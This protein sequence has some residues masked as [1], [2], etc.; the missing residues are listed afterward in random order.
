MNRTDPV[1]LTVS[2]PAKRRNFAGHVRRRIV[3]RKVLWQ[4]FIYALLLGGGI[5]LMIPLF[6]MVSTSLKPEDQL[7]IFLAI[8]IPQPLQWSNYERA[9]TT[10]PLGSYVINSILITGLNIVGNLLGSSLAA[11]SFARLRFPGRHCLF[12]VMLS[13]M[14]VPYWVTLVPTFIMFRLLGW[15]NTFAPL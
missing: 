1:Q 12:L 8:W 7:F 4:L 11:F 13:T 2:T 15:T 6:W 10:V 9:W 3:W 14:M 5:I